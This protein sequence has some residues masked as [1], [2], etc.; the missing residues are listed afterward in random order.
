MGVLDVWQLLNIL[1]P[2][3]YLKKTKKKLTY[4]AYTV[5]LG[6]NSNLVKLSL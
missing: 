5:Q 3:L 6:E 2:G 1:Y 4:R